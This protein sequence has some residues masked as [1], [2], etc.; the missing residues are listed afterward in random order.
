MCARVNLALRVGG[1][2]VRA[3]VRVL[4]RMCVS[5]RVL[6][7]LRATVRV[8]ATDFKVKLQVATYCPWCRW[9]SW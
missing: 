8:L 7:R 1:G 4:A 6:E 2:K 5:V 9:C 3:K